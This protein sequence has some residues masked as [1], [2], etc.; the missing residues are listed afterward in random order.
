MAHSKQEVIQSRVNLRDA[1]DREVKI[2]RGYI[3][4]LENA[5]RGLEMVSAPEIVALRE[6][7]VPAVKGFVK[8]LTE[9]MTA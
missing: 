6:D 1:I 9:K 5:L 8:S 3:A 7:D 2:H 4:A